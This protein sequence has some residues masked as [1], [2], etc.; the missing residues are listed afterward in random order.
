MSSTSD[1]I[2]R[3]RAGDT[4]ALARAITLVENRDPF[5]YDVGQRD[6]QTDRL[7]GQGRQ[8]EV[9]Q[10]EPI[11]PEQPELF[12]PGQLLGDLDRPEARVDPPI[13]LLLQDFQDLGLLFAAHNADRV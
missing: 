13:P 12:V 11:A 4:R 6:P 5:A 2:G 7:E 10:T 1:L 8:V 9:E 3:V